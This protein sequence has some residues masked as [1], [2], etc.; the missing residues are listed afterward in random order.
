MIR[1]F[2]NYDIYALG[3]VSNYRKACADLWGLYGKSTIFWSEQC[4]I[5]VDSVKTGV[6]AKYIK[7]YIPEKKPHFMKDGKHHSDKLCGVLYDILRPD[8]SE[9]KNRY[10]DPELSLQDVVSKKEYKKY[11]AIL[12]M[13]DRMKIPKNMITLTEK[14]I[15]DLSDKLD[16]N[17]C[18]NLGKILKLYGN[19][20]QKYKHILEETKGER[21]QKLTK[22]NNLNLSQRDEKC[23][24]LNEDFLT[25]FE[26]MYKDSREKL[27]MARLWYFIGYEFYSNKP[28]ALEFTWI[29]YKYLISIKLD[30]IPG[31]GDPMLISPGLSSSIKFYS[32]KPK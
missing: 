32:N 28:V 16:R 18:S 29:L 20:Q 6:S 31:K 1:D 17:T 8:K 22:K 5:A 25:C 30:I 23:K 24:Q 21:K 7:A 19:Y 10:I 12:Q 13:R 4:K 27:D 15:E 3:K 26:Y 9:Q 11:L 2:V 14:Q